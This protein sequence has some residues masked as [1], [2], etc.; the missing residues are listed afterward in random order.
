[1]NSAR[2]KAG[3]IVWLSLFLGACASFPDAPQVTQSPAI[4]DD[5]L[6]S[7]DGARLGLSVWE[8]ENPQAIIIAFHGMNDYASAFAL[9]GE[10]WSKE[11]GI[12][13]YAV[14]QRGFGRSPEPGRWPG[15]ETL[16]TDLRAAVH[17]VRKRH[18][19]MSIY[20]AGHSMGAGVVLAAMKEEALPVTGAILAAPGVWG[21]SQLPFLYRAGVN[22]AATFAPGKTLTGERAERQSS[23]NIPIL[24]AMYKDPLV[25]KEMRID[26]V[27]GVVRLMGD[28]Y[29]ATDEVGGDILFLYGEKD[30]IIPV[31]SMERA[32]ERLCGEV[33]TRIYENGWHLLFR[34]LQ[35]E[36][37]WRDVAQWI[38][39]KNTAGPEVGVGPAVSVCANS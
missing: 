5:A 29:D 16:T 27:L 3:C 32:V 37:V 4:T 2:L 21:G 11:A 19:N 35:A 36:N 39:K 22:I 31:K 18:P 28:A 34:D 25:I 26:A 20:I 12:T 17:A 24:R 1:M 23:D 15:N 7:I 13:T 6:V 9:A 30:E 38:E 8:A 14:D 10:W 33:E